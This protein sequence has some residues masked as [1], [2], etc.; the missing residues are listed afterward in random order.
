MLPNVRPN[1][2]LF[3]RNPSAKGSCLKSYMAWDGLWTPIPELMNSGVRN[4]E[5]SGH[6]FEVGWRGS[7][8][9]KVDTVSKI[10]RLSSQPASSK[11]DPYFCLK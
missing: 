1:V 5:R 10:S 7:P 3:R 8:D 4:P 6:N 11:L 9:L 2:Y